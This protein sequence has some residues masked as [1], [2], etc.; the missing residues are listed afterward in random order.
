MQ[1]MYFFGAIWDKFALSLVLFG[2]K[3]ALSLVLISPLAPRLHT[4]LSP[5]IDLKDI[6]SVYEVY[7]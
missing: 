6:E 7:F 2:V 5:F 1:I 4:P 3:F